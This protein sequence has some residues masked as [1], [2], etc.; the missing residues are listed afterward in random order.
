MSIW[1]LLSYNAGGERRQEWAVCNAGR[2]DAQHQGLEGT[3][4]PLGHPQVNGQFVIRLR[5]RG[6][7]AGHIGA[8]NR[9]VKKSGNRV[10][11]EKWV[12]AARAG[13]SQGGKELL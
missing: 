8:W 2:N 5:R 10:Y 12:D 7:N 6:I 4:A 3:P 1:L 11:L 9:N 13:E